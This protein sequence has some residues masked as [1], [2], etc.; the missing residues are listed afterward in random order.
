MVLQRV[1]RSPNI[2]AL[3]VRFLGAHY[4]KRIIRDPENSMGIYLGPYSRRF[5][6]SWFTYPKM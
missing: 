2:G 5:C 1:L 6:M 4:T 3:I